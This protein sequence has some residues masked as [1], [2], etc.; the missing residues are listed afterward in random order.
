MDKTTG[1]GAAGYAPAALKIKD[2]EFVSDPSIEGA[3]KGAAIGFMVG[4]PLGAAIGG[5]LGGIFGP[6]SSK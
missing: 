2:G 6:S 3:P 5:V 4:G 1:K